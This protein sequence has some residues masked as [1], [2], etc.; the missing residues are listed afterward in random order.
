M[1]DRKI[2][3]HFSWIQ[4]VQYDSEL[5]HI[6]TPEWMLGSLFTVNSRTVLCGGGSEKKQATYQTSTLQVLDEAPDGPICDKCMAILREM[7][8]LETTD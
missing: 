5:V 4:Y 8:R 2:L 3:S 7:Y 1:T 6:K